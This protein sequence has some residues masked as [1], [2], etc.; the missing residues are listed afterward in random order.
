MVRWIDDLKSALV[1][2]SALGLAAASTVPLLLPSLPAEARSLPLPLPMFCIA[3]A[4]QLIV[5]YG[6]LGF[7]GIRLARTRGLEPAPYLTVIWNPRATRS[8]WSRALV[9]FTFGLGCGA[10]LVAA[11]AGIQRCLPGTLPGTLHPPGMIAALLAST[12]G[13]GR[14]APRYFVCVRS[15]RRPI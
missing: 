14:N 3:L 9:A 2:S 13:E 5:L 4:A 15:E 10:L 8:G 11:V 12:T 1:L 7:A 6:L